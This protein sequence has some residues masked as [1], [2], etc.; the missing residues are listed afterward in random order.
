[1]GKTTSRGLSRT[2]R[3]H[4]VDSGEEAVGDEIGEAGR[5]K[6]YNCPPT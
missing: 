3:F 5:L 2:T 4:Y 1:M 6:A